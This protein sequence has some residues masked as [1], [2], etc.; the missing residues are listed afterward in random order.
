VGARTT[1]GWRDPG[2]LR[3][4]GR[5]H[6]QSTLYEMVKRVTVQRRSSIRERC[7]RVRGM[8]VFQKK[9]NKLR[10]FASTGLERTGG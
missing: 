2:I 6:N 7:Q 9:T 5:V 3:K 1:K 10:D 4:R 8:W